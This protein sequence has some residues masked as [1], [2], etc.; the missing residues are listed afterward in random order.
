MTNYAVMF[1]FRD[2]VS[3]NGFL[4]GIT[5]SGR[6]LMA[7]EDG[8]W[9]VYGVRPGAIAECGKTPFEAFAH[10]RNRYT[11]VLF[12]IAAESNTFHVFR[13]EVERFYYQPDPGEEKR[14]EEA[15][16]ALREGKVIPEKPFC[17]LP[18]ENPEDRP[19]QITIARLDEMKRFTPSDNVPDKY[20]MAAA[21]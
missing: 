11:G 9:W 15:F 20:V 8:L 13:R 1:T 21:A 18:H 5:L 4:A 14:W 12:D 7:E 17:D 2:A 19:S 10:F 3:G 16:L 6:G